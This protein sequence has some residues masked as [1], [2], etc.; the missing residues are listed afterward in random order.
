MQHRLPIK[1]FSFLIPCFICNLC[2]ALEAYS[3]PNLELDINVKLDSDGL[4]TVLN[5][6]MQI[7][8]WN[9]KEHCFYL[10]YL[11]PNYGDDR[12]D[13][14]KFSPKKS[15]V[16]KRTFSGG[17]T[18]VT[19][20][21]RKNIV[22]LTP[23][24]FKITPNHQKK[25]SFNVQSTIPRI[26]NASK[27]DFFYR[28]FYPQPLSSCPPQIINESIIKR[29]P[30]LII[31]SKIKIARPE[32]NAAGLNS[33]KNIWQIASSGQIDSCFCA[34]TATTE[35]KREFVFAISNQYKVKNLTKN[36]TPI[37]IFYHSKYAES[38]F[39]TIV[40]SLTNHTNWLGPYPF[41]ELILVETAEVHA[42]GIPGFV[43]F[44]LPRQ[45]AFRSLQNKF[46][47]WPHWMI[48]Q[49]LAAQWFLGSTFSNAKKDKWFFEGFNHFLVYQFLKSKPK[50]FDLF[51]QSSLV[52][53]ILS[54][55][56]HQA[57]DITASIFRR[58]DPYGTLT[59]EN[60]NSIHS[61]DNQNPLLFIR[62]SLALR[63]ISTS[64]GEEKMKI[65]LRS[66]YNYI[67]KRESKPADMVN[68]TSFNIQGLNS[69]EKELISYCL[70]EWWTKWQW[71]DY[72]IESIDRYKNS[73]SN[74]TTK[75][76]IAQ[77]EN[78]L[79]PVPIRLTDAKG[80]EYWKNSFPTDTNDHTSIVT[81]KT[82]APAD[83]IEIDPER[84][85]F[86]SDRFNNSNTL[87]SLRF[88]PG[89]AKTFYDDSYTIFWGPYA[90]RRPGEPFFLGV[91]GA[92]FRYLNSSL[93]F[94]GERAFTDDL[95]AFSLRHKYNLP[96][97]AIKINTSVNQDFRGSR[98]MLMEVGRS[99]IFQSGPKL[100]GLLKIR[101][102]QTVG[103]F[104]TVHGTIGAEANMIPASN[105]GDCMYNLTGESEIA[106]EAASPEFTYRK[107]IGKA[108]LQCNI[109][110]Y[111]TLRLKL[112]R[113][114]IHDDQ[115]P[116]P[117]ETKF[118]IN[119]MEQAQIRIDSDNIEP[120][121]NIN[122]TTIA[123]DTPLPISISSETMILSRKAR[124]QFF[125][126]Y[127]YALSEEHKY[128]IFRA[129][130]I[131]LNLPFGGDIMGAGSLAL[132]NFSLATILYSYND[133][134][135]DKKP[136]YLFSVNSS[137]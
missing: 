61:S 80:K 86:D 31:S 106:P 108:Q 2:Y 117:E 131:Q 50:L 102:R 104:N 19:S 16:S 7:E 101:R 6:Q 87:P 85:V 23:Y 122:S 12:E 5:T 128:R 76:H 40:D 65:F 42:L 20:L 1:F 95:G 18:Q 8:T 36:A 130:G 4:P 22:F 82:S 13:M 69:L 58:N 72:S 92:I 107:E 84:T 30:S 32:L 103:Q 132:F 10:P 17:S 37:R 28:G 70:K 74:W 41:S 90:F 51:N 64:I 136:S 93:F 71:P 34:S 114:L 134:K 33:D 94:S 44:N 47:N 77:N 98:V 127:G 133:G 99:P 125:Y 63:Q 124:L 113:G 59:D 52:S 109:F 21:D 116:I 119:D 49:Q 75:V 79:L 89:T 123:F 112:F 126:D 39:E 62:H 66:F 83:E 60:F 45:G 129:S 88:F 57:Q 100:S 121:K 9:N 105:T 48:S 110:K 53:K 56:Y 38:L 54:M 14:R 81:F 24:I 46:L 118:F 68:F 78:I 25:F 137:L 91:G 15:L 97:A 26:S 11:D 67:E 3:I 27:I 115:G 55:S 111:F 43:P 29:L 96:Q 135:I 120:S 73:E 35:Q